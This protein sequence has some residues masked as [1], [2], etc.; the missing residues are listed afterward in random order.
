MGAQPMNGF[1]IWTAEIKMDNQA[2][3]LRLSWRLRGTFV[4]KKF[5]TIING[6]KNPKNSF[7]F[8]FFRFTFFVPK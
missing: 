5:Q 3:V 8:R 4:V 6:E 7:R 1:N 2:K